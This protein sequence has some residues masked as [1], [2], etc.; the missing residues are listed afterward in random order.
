MRAEV[1]QMHKERERYEEMMKKA[2]MRGV[3]ALNLEAM[4]IF[5]SNEEKEN[6]D[7]GTVVVITIT[8]PQLS[9][10]MHLYHT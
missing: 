8:N 2:F 9:Y 4:T 10:D 5:H 7:I 6:R 1:A 3:C